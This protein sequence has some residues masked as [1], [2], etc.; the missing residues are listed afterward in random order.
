V[1]YGNVSFGS[2][3][4]LL[5]ASGRST[6]DVQSRADDVTRSY[7]FYPRRLKIPRQDAKKRDAVRRLAKVPCDAKMLKSTGFPELFD[8]WLT[9][10]PKLD[11][12]GSNPVARCRNYSLCRNRDYY[13]AHRTI[14]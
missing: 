1:P 2:R 6:A 7:P 8:G 4:V 14:G 3:S 5:P 13:L 9:D 10:F 12:A 11:V